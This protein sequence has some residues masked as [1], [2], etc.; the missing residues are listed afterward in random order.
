M[1]G[2]RQKMLTL[3]VED[4]VAATGAQLIAG[5]ASICVKKVVRDSREV[6]K[7]TLFVCFPGDR[8]DGNDFA[9]ASIEAGV[10]AV[11]LTREAPA[12]LLSQAKAAGC[13][14]LRAAGDDPTEFL[15]RLAAEWRRR[16]P[17]WAVVGITGSV[18][19]TTTKDMVSFGLRTC[20][21]VHATSGNYNNLVGVPLTILSAS[22]D[23][24][25]VVCEMG[26]N[27]KGELSRLTSVVRPTIAAITNIGT[28]HIGLLGSR[29]AIARAKSEIIEGLP[30]SSAAVDTAVG[31]LSSRLVLSEDNDFSSL[32]E[33]QY[34]RPAGVDIL[35]VGTSEEAAVSHGVIKLD[36]SGLPFFK[37]RF[38]D[39]WSYEAKLKIA[40][41]A[42][43]MD[44]LFAMAICAYLGVDRK[45]AAHAI[46]QMPSAHMRLELRKL[47]GRP[48]VIDDSYNASPASMASALQVLSSLSCR[49]RRVAVLGEMGE[50][51][52]E[53][54][55]LHGYVGAY[56]AAVSPDFV[57][58]VGKDDAREM[59]EAALTMGYEE[60]RMELFPDVSSALSA[61][62]PKLCQDD[63]VLVKASRAVGLDEFVRRVLA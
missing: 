55:R 16:N 18:G 14:V 31:P 4:I 24:Q 58:W 23:D 8:V 42:A 56:V 61:V 57:V 13:A 62:A 54:A 22:A 25:V 39:G 37:L 51:G 46:E 49:G 12:G 6:G 43:V 50:L 63:L 20:W 26:M 29:E 33:Q 60:G 27:H 45:K 30:A 32:I 9:S 35:R 41:T 34:C 2:E 28:S 59:Q 10:A 47:P 19:K 15:L 17:Q 5:T 38:A 1:T 3:C 52:A 48:R 11:A 7:G 36:E 40:G 44:F 53:S 21:R